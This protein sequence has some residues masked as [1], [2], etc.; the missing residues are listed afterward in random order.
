[1]RKINFYCVLLAI[2]SVI[3]FASCDKNNE[4]R[5]YI[6]V[7]PIEFKFYVLDKDSVNLL[8]DSTIMKEYMDKVKVIYNNNEYKCSEIVD[9]NKSI[10]SRWYAPFFKGLIMFDNGFSSSD[11]YVLYFGEFDG[12][13]VYNE[14]SFTIDWGDGTTDDIFFKGSYYNMKSNREFYL[15]G[16]LIQKGE[17]PIFVYKFIK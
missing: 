14:I 12:S 7:Y 17:S 9:F 8:N 11:N 10:Q 4:T 16:E 6:D 13:L 15:N 3:S 2:L 1:M 5:M